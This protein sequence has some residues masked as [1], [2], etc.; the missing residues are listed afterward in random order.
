MS[1]EVNQETRSKLFL[2]KGRDALCS[3]QLRIS[4]RTDGLLNPPAIFLVDSRGFST[5]KINFK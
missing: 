2:P 1:S 4:K 3:K 5:F